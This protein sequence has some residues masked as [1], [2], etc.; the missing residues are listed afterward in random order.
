MIRTA[1]TKRPLSGPVSRQPLRAV[2]L[3]NP[4]LRVLSPIPGA[5]QEDF[6]EIF[7]G[8]VSTP[9]LERLDN[10]IRAAF[11]SAITGLIREKRLEYDGS[12]IRRKK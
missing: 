5:C 9:G 4:A 8:E 2:H 7:Q 11:A 10:N 12:Q 3:R 1:Q 6:F